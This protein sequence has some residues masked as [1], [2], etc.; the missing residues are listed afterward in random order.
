MK[1][2]RLTDNKPA[3]TSGKLY[4]VLDVSYGISEN[5]IV[6]LTI[7][8]DMNSQCYYSLHGYHAVQEFK[9]NWK[10]LK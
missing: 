1:F 2:K 7:E 6:G 10:E 9:R 5:D 3:Y 4:R 8:N